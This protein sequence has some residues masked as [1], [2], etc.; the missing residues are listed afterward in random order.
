[1]NK[2]NDLP[3]FKGKTYVYNVSPHTNLAMTN[4]M[5]YFVHKAG[6][7]WLMKLVESAQYLQQICQNKDFIVWRIRV[8]KNDT[9]LVEAYKD[10]PF[11]V[12]NLLFRQKLPYTDFEEN[13]GISSYE[14]YQEGDVLLLK[15]EH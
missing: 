1:M 3:Q 5:R 8:D 2:E 11:V 7:Y 6:C 9:G 15:S 14:F 13:T 4:S 12:K 10:S